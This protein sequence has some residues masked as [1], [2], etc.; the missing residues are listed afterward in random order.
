MMNDDMIRNIEY[1]REK[2]DVSYE[3]AM[4]LLDRYDGN[5]M[6]VLVELEHQGRVYDQPAASGYS[7]SNAEWQQAKEEAKEKANSFF[8]KAL[9]TRLVVEKKGEKGEKETIA[10]LNLPFAA[11]VAIVAPWVTLG[12]AALAFATGHN[13]KLETESDEKKDEEKTEN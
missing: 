10:N 13:V 11:G 8:G 12:T 4:E 9:K 2:A 6:R 7:A 1:L 3:E 5:V